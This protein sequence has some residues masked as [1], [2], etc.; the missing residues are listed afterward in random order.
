[1][2]FLLRF[3]ALCLITACL[4]VSSTDK[5][6]KHNTALMI[7]YIIIAGFIFLS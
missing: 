7:A 3:A 4:L 1:M 6:A 2:G 5:W